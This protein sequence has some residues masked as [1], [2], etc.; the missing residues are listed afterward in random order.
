MGFRISLALLAVLAVACS[1]S[2][3]DKDTGPNPPDAQQQD[4]RQDAQTPDAA[5]DAAPDA[6]ANPACKSSGKQ[7]VTFTTEDSVKLEADLYLGGKS[8]GAAVVL[9]HMVPPANDRTNYPAAFIDA[10]VAKGLTVLNVDRRGAGN[11]EGVATEAYTG[12]KGKLDAKAAYEHLAAH[13]CPIDTKRIG[14]VGASN[15]TATALDFTVHAGSEAALDVPAALVFLTGGPYTE[16]QNT[17]AASLTLLEKI[18]ILF[19]YSDAESSWSAGFKSGNV[20]LWQFLEYTGV[21][22]GEGHGTAIF[23]AKP[24]SIDAVVTFLQQTL[25]P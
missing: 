6:P 14:F 17:L 7:V 9:L 23:T 11:S 21:S 5:P 18:P 22:A 10:L 19:V 3:P 8:G 12:P 2:D 25:A 16:A 1:D 20:A 4:A 13:A 24:E 15:G